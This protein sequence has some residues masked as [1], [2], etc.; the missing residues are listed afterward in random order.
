MTTTDVTPTAVTETVLTPPPVVTPK[1][2]K[3]IKKKPVK[4]TPVKKTAAKKATKKK[5]EPTSGQ[6]GPPIDLDYEELNARET[7]VVD[8]LNGEGGGTR[9]IRTIKEL[10]DAAF[11]SKTKKQA[12]SWVR[13]QL[14]RLVCAGWVEKVE[15]GSYRVSKKGRDRMTRVEA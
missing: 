2:K 1:V 7:K 3:A 5:S 8:V 4:K 14:R 11:P 13:N 15:R 6:S 12:N 9:E 10:A